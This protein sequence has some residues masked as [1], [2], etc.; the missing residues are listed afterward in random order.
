[1]QLASSVVSPLLRVV[2]VLSKYPERAVSYFLLAVLSGLLVG[3][4][5][6]CG[7]CIALRLAPV[8]DEPVNTASTRV[9]ANICTTLSREDS[10]SC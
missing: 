7:E 9:R 6:L 2:F 1:M 8:D 3:V 4:C 5:C 10:I